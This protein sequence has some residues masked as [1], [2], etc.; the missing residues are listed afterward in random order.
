MDILT[1]AGVGL[2]IV[3]FLA[4]AEVMRRR[5]G[6]DS[7]ITRKFVHL[8]TG[9]L[10]LF[11]P[12][13][14]PDPT[15]PIA[16]TSIFTVFLIFALRNNW[17]PGV[18]G[19]GEGRYGTLYF[20]LAFLFLTIFCWER[21][22]VVLMA[23]M[24][25][26]TWGDGLA[27]IVGGRLGRRTF[28]VN[29]GSKTLEG[30][31]TM[32]GASFL[33]LLGTL[34]LYDAGSPA[35]ILWIALVVALLATAIELATPA[36]LD[37][38]TIALATA[39]FVHFMLDATPIE[40][41]VFTLGVLMSMGVALMAY[42]SGALDLSGTFG[43]FLLGTVIFGV[44]GWR[45]TLPVLVFF[46]S[47]TI[48]GRLGRDR[49]TEITSVVAKEGARD[50]YQS[51]ANAGLA[52]AIIIVW[53]FFEDARLYYVFLGTLA[54]VTADT[55][56]SEIGV[57]SKK[58]PVS[59]ATGKPVPRGLSGGVTRLGFLAGLVG[60][61]LVVSTGLLF[62]AH[63]TVGNKLFLVILAAGFLGTIADSL[64]GATIQGIFRC[65][66]CENLTE[67]RVHCDRQETVLHSGSRF[68]NND[69]VNVM[70]GFSG[71]LFVFLALAFA[72]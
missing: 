49:R 11:A 47:S 37:N 7:E 21:E 17:L 56:S 28:W 9:T 13:I 64:L 48:I 72:R 25:V 50:L 29:K 6:V 19:A 54:A 14:F 38:L 23:G 44:G 40:N 51:M 69:L 4:M 1:A 67:R 63:L 41:A 58:Q 5:L 68:V 57:L 71:G 8:A 61:L 70:C 24:Q 62:D 12:R 66:S 43:A 10:I 35:L 59:M 26:L 15:A 18:H 16:I 3:A 60:S 32:F 52:M 30:T 33:A 65:P 34:A 22:Q 27:A 2:A 45:W 39:F 36:G 55:W 46:V 20:A 31:A 53:Y 42:R